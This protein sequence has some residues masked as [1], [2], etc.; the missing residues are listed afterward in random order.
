MKNA[1]LLLILFPLLSQAQDDSIDTRER[2][3]YAIK[4]AETPIELDGNES[5]NEWDAHEV[6]TN[7]FNHW[8][9]DE[10][11]AEN[12]TEVKITYDE[13]NIYVLAKCYDSN[14][15]II[16][17][18]VRD[19]SADYWGSDN[20]TLV[21]DP[22]NS[23]Q[24]GF[25]FGITAGGAEMEGSLV[26]EGSQTYN[27][28]NWDNKWDSKVTQYDGYW[29]AEISI[30][31]KTLRYNPNQSSWGI[32]FIRGDKQKNTYTTWTQFPVNFNGVSMNF[33]GSLEW[34]IPPV[35][36]SGAFIF[37]PYI[38]TSSLRNHEN[39]DQ[40]KADNTIDI[41]GD[42]KVALSS[43]LNLDLTLLPDFSN[44]DVDQEITNIS[45]FNIFLP[46]QR[47]FFLENNDI[48]SSFGSYDIKPFFSRKIGIMDGQAV[49]I[50]YGGRLTGNINPNLRIGVMDVQTDETG[51]F[52]GQNYA[53]GAFQQKILKRSVIKGIFINRQATS[54]TESNEFSRNAGL[55]F[56]YISENGKFNNTFMYHASIT[57]EKSSKNS[58]YGINGTYLTKR[59]RTGWE[60]NVVDDNYI[61]E[62]GINPRLQNYNAETGETVRLGYT[63]INPWVRYLT[64]VEDENRKLNYHGLRTWHFLYLNPNGS[65]NES[66]NNFGYDFEYKNTSR[67]VLLG[68]YRKV[69]LMFPTSLLGSD[70]A[71]LPIDDYS[72]SSFEFR[73]RADS[74]KKFSWDTNVS[75][76]NFFN[77]TRLRANIKGT[78]RIQPWGNFGLS[79]NFNDIKLKEGFGADKIHLIR[80]NGDISFSNKIAFKNVV[81]YNSLSENLSVFS[82]VQW[83]YKP[84]SDIYLIFNENHGLEGMG[85]KNRSIVL[86]MTHWF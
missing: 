61:T 23:K 73:Y 71:P 46:E 48:F 47:N 69:N 37:N 55:E 44:A 20:F 57:P 32:N 22:V 4:K 74:R 51:D 33:M 27:S 11:Q 9:K 30:P 29:M 67:L 26:I 42:V 81:Q 38:T 5:V 39:P 1:L 35:K 85:I 13:N 56:S 72:F 78:Y 63:L 70:Y 3:K 82:R 14:D 10:G 79:Y 60:I 80:F 31:F 68:R 86:K 16:Q 58:F 15:R 36:A 66:Q 19:N 41:G 28:E 49:P 62:V 8:P 40:S 77:G 84:M 21:L 83:R 59:F 53:V 18:L 50:N 2:F 76:G 43:S 7:F 17:S 25:L 54:S 12:Q 75:Y 64:F 52:A 65:L 34:D 6:A 24:S 45:R